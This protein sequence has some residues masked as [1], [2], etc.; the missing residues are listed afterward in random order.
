MVRLDKINDPD[1]KEDPKW[2]KIAHTENHLDCK[3]CDYQKSE[4]SIPTEKFEKDDGN[5]NPILVNEITVV[6]GKYDEVMGWLF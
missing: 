4:D 1:K 6:R 5:G 3:R 2:E